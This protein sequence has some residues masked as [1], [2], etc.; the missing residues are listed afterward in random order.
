MYL[1][2]HVKKMTYQDGFIK[3]INQFSYDDASLN[4][5]CKCYLSDLFNQ[6]KIIKTD[7]G[8]PITFHKQELAEEQY[9]I[10]IGVEGIQLIFNTDKGLYL[11]LTTLKQILLQC[12]KK[13][14][15]L[16]ID[17]EPDFSNRGLMLDIS[18]NR[19][20][21]I[22]TIKKIIDLLSDVKINQ[23]Q[24]N[25]EGNSYYYPNEKECYTKKDDYLTAEDIQEL[26]QYCQRKNITLVGNQNS[27]GHMA[28]WLSLQKYHHLAECPDGFSY[29]WIENS[30]STTLNPQLEESYQFVISLYDQYFPAYSSSLVNIGCDEPFELGLGKSKELVAKEGKGKV[31]ASFVCRLIDYLKK[32]GK[33]VMMW[34]DV[35]KENP[36]AFDYLSNDV[37]ALEWGYDRNDFHDEELLQYQ[38]KNFPFYVCPGTSMWNTVV[39]KYDNMYHNILR[40]AKMG[41]KYQAIGMLTT[42]WGDGGSWQQLSFSF[43]PYL[44]GACYA[45][46]QQ[47]EYEEDIL[48]YADEFI[49]HE[50]IAHFIKEISNSYQIEK[51]NESNATK[52]F[53]LAY[54]Q[55]TDGLHFDH[56]YSDPMSVG[57]DKVYL[58]YEEYEQY[59]TFFQKKLQELEKFHLASIIKHE[60]LFSLLLLNGS[61]MIGMYLSKD[62]LPYEFYKQAV[63]CLKAALQEFHFTWKIRNKKSDYHLSV[64]R[65]K[66]FYEKCKINLVKS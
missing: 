20:Y 31:Y 37:I 53:K 66:T 52:L 5:A 17:D 65:L 16:Q 45:W 51:K 11:A 14:P 26:D 49:Y 18:R 35:I 12:P 4:E 55:H 64:Y 44:I 34:G 3:N 22:D 62:A 57:Y 19:V 59:H 54:M 38:K 61:A 10:H 58:S 6:G 13:I 60:L 28:Y 1:I 25:V 2:P 32:Q 21:Q 24:F 42:D 15:Y 43:L 23:L 50:K 33:K 27:F 7:N 8:I 9:L 46:N 29:R 63:A 39:G 41:K 56:N 40:A 30:F 47:E 48:R 36:E